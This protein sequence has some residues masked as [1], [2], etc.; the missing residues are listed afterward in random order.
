MIAP[1]LTSPERPPV[2]V[3]LAQALSLFRANDFDAAETLYGEILQDD[4]GNPHALHIQGLLYEQRGDYE[5][6]EQLIWRSIQMAPHSRAWLNLGVIRQHRGLPNEAIAA[7]RT[8]IELEPTYAEAWTNLI[9]AL[10]LHPHATPSL[11][12]QTRERFDHAVCAPLTALSQ[13]HQNDRDPDRRLKVGYVSGDFRL[14]H[15]AAMAFHWIACHDPAQVEVFCYS[16][17]EGTDPTDAPFRERADVWAEIGHLNPLELAQVIR[18][19]RID[20][21]VDLSGVSKGGRPL[22]FA[23]KPAPIQV[24]GW[25]YSS[26]LGIRAMDYLVAD[27]VAMPAAHAD[28]YPER[29]LHLPSVIAYSPPA[30]LPELLAPPERQRGYRTYGYLGRPV[31]LTD[32]CLAAWAEI[33][34]RDPVSRLLLKS[35]QYADRLMRER[36]VNTLGALGVSM[37]RIEIQGVT[38][39]YEHLEAHSD[40]DVCLDSFPQNGGMTT[41]DALLMGVPVVTLVGE[42]A[43]ARASASILTAVGEAAYICESVEEYINWTADLSP[44]PRQQIRDALLGSILV[45]RGGYVAKVEAAYRMIWRQWAEAA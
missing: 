14:S 13:P 4:P 15:S 29:L 6:A 25:G 39:R 35:G 37:D 36:V 9:F 43:P 7:Y 44:P 22:T 45:D 3:R 17:Y 40:V 16:T 23:L 42:T 11:L 41:M 1:V 5:M 34:R 21:L 32:A 31:K 30:T 12:R 24:G 28:R 18:D 20:I 2:A 38:S 10:D 27:H 33:L 26:G 19:D 8:A